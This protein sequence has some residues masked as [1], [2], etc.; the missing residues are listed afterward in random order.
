MTAHVKAYQTTV[1][2]LSSHPVKPSH[3]VSPLRQPPPFG[4]KRL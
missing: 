1:T 2:G 4:G 3:P